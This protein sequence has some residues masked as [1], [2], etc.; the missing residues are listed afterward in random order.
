[1]QF[2][3]GREING[4]DVTV[5]DQRGEVCRRAGNAVGFGVAS[6][7][8][9]IRTEHRDDLAAVRTNSPDHVLRSDGTRADQPPTQTPAHG[10][11]NPWNLAPQLSRTITRASPANDRLTGSSRRIS[12]SKP[13]AQRMPISLVSALTVVSGGALCSASA[14]S[15]NP[16][17]AISRPTTIPRKASRPRCAHGDDVVVTGERGWRQWNGKRPLDRHAPT[18]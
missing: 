3:V 18:V 16:T 17:T 9:R 2:V 10:T 13:S 11:P 5:F 1:M 12:P 14:M 7:T 6:P 4:I 8:R 15:S